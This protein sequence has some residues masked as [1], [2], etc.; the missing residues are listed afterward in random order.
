MIEEVWTNGRGKIN[1]GKSIGAQGKGTFGHLG[2]IWRREGLSKIDLKL[3]EV[4]QEGG[5]DWK[6][7]NEEGGW[8]IDAESLTTLHC[9]GGCSE[10]LLIEWIGWIRM[11]T[12]GSGK[13][14][15]WLK[16]KGFFLIY[17]GI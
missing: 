16:D 5:E 14:A 15:W 2:I 13:L 6:G 8:R 12:S 4:R 7:R 11:R 1:E 10:M 17:G 3:T 9:F